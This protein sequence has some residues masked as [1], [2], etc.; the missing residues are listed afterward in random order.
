MIIEINLFTG[1][2]LFL[3]FLIY[4][5]LKRNKMTT[6]ERIIKTIFFAYILLLLKYAIFPIYLKTD[7]ADTMRSELT[8]KEIISTN[9]NLLPFFS[10]FNLRD[11]V[12][13][14]IMTLPFGFLMG[15]LK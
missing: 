4:L 11:F 12:L 7:I 8:L 3:P 10:G 13:N 5:I 2:I 9:V 6:R 15:V 14:I 1:A